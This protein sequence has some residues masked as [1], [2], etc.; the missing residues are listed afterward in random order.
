[1]ATRSN[2]VANDGVENLSVQFEYDGMLG[3]V[4]A[5]L[6]RIADMMSECSRRDDERLTQG[7]VSHRSHSWR[8]GAIN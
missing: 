5:T 2:N 1:M 4:D 8:R 6:S 7:Y 3:K